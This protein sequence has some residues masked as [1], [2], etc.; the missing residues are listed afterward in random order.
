MHA[1][2]DTIEQKLD[3]ARRRLLDMS[4]RNRLLNY[5]AG[6]NRSLKI[7][8]ADPA[9]VYR[10]L[11]KG[12]KTRLDF[13]AA[14]EAGLK[15]DGEKGVSGD[16][17]NTASS[18]DTTAPPQERK[19]TEKSAPPRAR[20][21]QE[22]ATSM[23]AEQLERRL[24]F[25]DREAESALQE[26]GC[27]ILYLALGMVGWKDTAAGSVVSYAPL[28]L[29][30]VDLVRAG[31]GDRHRLVL[32]DQ[33]ITVNPALGE[34]CR[35]EYRVSLP[36][37]I[38]NETDLDEYFQSVEKAI[39]K[40]P[41]WTIQKDVHLGLFTFAK[42]LM[43]LDLD[44]TRWPEQSLA[45]HALVRGLCGLPTELPECGECTP[46]DKLDEVPPR[47]TFQVLDADS[48]Q[49]VAILAAKSGTSM[50]IEGPP[51]TGKSQ[52]ITNIIAECLSQ[53]KTVL[54]VAEKA[55]ALEVVKRRLDNVQLGDFV[56]ELHSRK[57]SKR[58]IIEELGRVMN[59]SY[60]PAPRFDLDARE[61]EQLRARL[62]SYVRLLHE[63]R[64][65][66]EKSLFEAMS[67]FAP[68]R[69]AVE[70]PVDMGALVSASRDEF[71]RMQELVALLSRAAS[72]L[73]DM[74]VHPWRGVGLTEISLDQRQ[75]LPEKIEGLRRALA[76]VE[77]TGRAVAEQ[78]EAP[79]PPSADLA[80]QFLELG[81][82]IL[83][84]ATITP[85]SLENVAAWQTSADVDVLLASGRRIQ[86]ARALL[87]THW[88]S[89]AEDID[90]QEL[91]E[92]RKAHLAT[93]WRWFQ[94]SFYS[95]NN[96]IRQQSTY[97]FVPPKA[98]VDDLQALIALRQERR[99][100]AGL[101]PQGSTFF[102]K[103]W[104]G[105]DS[106]WPS[107]AQHAAA[108]RMIWRDM[109]E[110]GATA[111]GIAA[112]CTSDGK[113][114]MT[115][116]IESLAAACAA[117]GIALKEFGEPLAID[118][119]RFVG[120]KHEAT[121][122]V[123]WTARLDPCTAATE[124]ISEWIDFNLANRNC[125]AAGL[126]SFLAWTDQRRDLVQAW[127]EVFQRQFLLTWI[128]RQFSQL[129]EFRE[130]QQLDHNALVERFRDADK[131]WLAMSQRRLAGE[132]A[133]RRPQS[134]GSTAKSSRLGVLEAEMRRKRGLKPIRQLFSQVGDVVQA[135]KP[136]LM[137]SP[138]SVA[139]YLA[140]GGM[141]FDVV[142]FDEA[143]QVEPAD[144]LGAVARGKQLILVGDEK[145]LP[146]TNFFNTISLA[147]EPPV[148]SDALDT[149]D[150]E[151]V[152]AQG[153][154]VLPFR[155]TLRWHY[156]SQH[157]SLIAFSN[158]QFYNHELRI[159]PSPQF[160]TGQVGLTF[161]HVPD[162][163][164][165]RAKGQYN[166]QEAQ[167]V[168]QAVLEHVRTRPGK[169]LGVGAFSV[170]QQ[171]AIQDAL[172]ALRKEANDSTLEHFFDRD[173][174]DPFFVKN[175]ETI[176]G[177][178]RDTIFLSVG[179][180]P[181]ETGKVSMNFGPL[182]K[183]GGWRRLNVLVT[184]AREQCIVFST[185]TADKINVGPGTPRGVQAIKDYLAFA[186]N[187]ARP[188]T[189]A[190]ANDHES[191]LESDIAQALATKGWKVESQVGEA[192]FSIDL[193][194]LD[195]RKPGR[196][197]M[198]IECD[199]ATYHGAAT[200]RDRDRLRQA[201]LEKLGWTLHRIWSTD[202][203]EKRESTL[204]ALLERLDGLVKQQE[205]VKQQATTAT[206]PTVESPK[207]GAKPASDL[208]PA[209]K[210]TE[211][212]ATE[213]PPKEKSPAEKHV[214]KKPVEKPAEKAN[215]TAPAMLRGVTPYVRY[216]QRSLGSRETL[217]ADGFHKL[218]DLV[219]DLVGIEGPIQVD[220]AMRVIVGLY[221][222]RLSGSSKDRVTDA[223]ELAV[224]SGRVSRR[225]EFLWTSKSTGA[226][227][228]W[229]GEDDAVTS[230]HLIPT[231]EVAAAAVLVAQQSFGVPA[232][233]LA[234]AALRAMGFK[235]ISQPL[236]ELGRAGVELAIQD[237][238]LT[239]DASGFLVPTEPGAT[240]SG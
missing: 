219:V 97:S 6:G 176:Q 47:D 199:G 119:S 35:R 183:D 101:D 217:L 152:L 121:T 84:T 233:D 25:L 55:A 213:R 232:D 165:L 190:A 226:A 112:A 144:A 86:Q 229:R 230:P 53:G 32:W 185:L 117:L 75:K 127:P 63:P 108:M 61:L 89:E 66:L 187:G 201:V 155:T 195:P 111:G 234:A 64:T 202:W 104:K 26:Q 62:N 99:R 124:R 186:Q 116:V 184:R 22:L 128:D 13:L 227:V 174:S 214:A 27:N 136:C 19:E 105:L 48:S 173:A 94:P 206:P 139:Q 196:Y 118:Y 41:G 181:D 5:R 51:G 160:E 192:S 98:V 235:R 74:A 2:P 16:A 12:D 239:A 37:E 76:E 91:F 92:R 18:Q 137:M 81:R 211:E 134:T 180:G 24:L 90:W 218:T 210:P 83:Q 133:Q 14:E 33:E 126:E 178:E 189:S 93:L 1:Q 3:E 85:E 102:G 46:A 240:Q 38:D 122:F 135:L 153:A 100:F 40:L 238:R 236:A 208:P 167:A 175:L 10:L 58:Q 65:A 50:V 125:K 212:P 123:D 39:E 150:L 194:I 87:A 28:V 228:R 110:G 163:I 138:I 20:Q 170:A 204:K 169:S 78:V 82:A 168:A 96:F 60:P 34:M 198:G 224:R 154:V 200:A 30:P 72:R 7:V 225:G 71:A 29:V 237:K 56:L 106:D 209:A 36:D 172:E 161:R 68:L 223:V 140:A 57:A 164:Y 220:E 67:E 115:R 88:K 59:A 79:G 207:D 179:Y 4:R 162:G 177:D 129:P 149:S 77:R 143:S 157:D 23:A 95:D 191:S 159:F 43:Y 188:A 80:Q 156:R 141:Q 221:S 222:A 17:A 69:T 9:A 171:A 52:T 15:P 205:P 182:N 231:E 120:Q 215:A 203:F 132:V 8:E 42:L 21:P 216:P 31:V 197:L 45:S 113:A 107:L 131:R 114:K 142:I 145:Q 151:S 146:P 193:A 73:G 109:A 54:F 148:A 130:F 158:D 70:A 147:E 49:Q 11:M 166:K 44:P 103:L